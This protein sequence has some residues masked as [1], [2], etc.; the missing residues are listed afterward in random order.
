M[1]LKKI[2]VAIDSPAA[3]GAGTISKLLAKK[4]NLLYCDTGKIYRFL[5]L[6]LIQKKPKNKTQYLS[7]ISKKI[8]LKKLQNKNLLNDRIAYVASQIAK[9]LP[10]RKLVLKFQRSL[11]YN[12]PK[13]FSGTILDGRDIITK[14]VPDADF[15]FYVTANV[16]VRARR[17]YLELKKMRKKVK[18]AEILKSMKKRDREDRTRKHSRLKKTKD[19]HLINTSNLSIKSSFLKV[20]KIMDRKLNRIWKK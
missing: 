18:F 16:N 8:D 11:A 14:I 6:K 10:T 9:D 15:K 13:R 12:P 7:K 19:S 1:K 20:K 17:R 3:S 2:K 4:Y 5:A